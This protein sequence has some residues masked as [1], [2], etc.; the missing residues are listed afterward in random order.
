MNEALL[1]A[2][3]WYFLALFI[4]IGASA[5]IIADESGSHKPVMIGVLAFGVVYVLSTKWQDT[6]S[7]VFILSA[8]LFMGISFLTSYV[9]PFLYMFTG[10]D[11]RGASEYVLWAILECLI[12]IPVM[13][14]IFRLYD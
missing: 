9:P 2:F 8:L 3:K 13:T 6:G 7:K 10:I 12:G 14:V 11:I 4:V 1:K 5:F